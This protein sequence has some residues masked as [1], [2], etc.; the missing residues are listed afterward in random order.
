MQ[1]CCQWWS[2]MQAI[3]WS[4][5]IL[6]EWPKALERVRQCHEKRVRQKPVFMKGMARKPISWYRASQYMLRAHYMRGYKTDAWKV[7]IERCLNQSRYATAAKPSTREVVATRCPQCRERTRTPKWITRC[8]QQHVS[9]TK[10]S[11]ESD[12]VRK[13]GGI[14]RG[15]RVRT[16]SQPQVRTT[17]V[18]PDDWEDSIEHARRAYESRAQYRRMPEWSKWAVNCASNHTKRV[19]WKGDKQKPACPIE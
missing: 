4:P 2:A 6:C 10:R 9:K 18:A 1:E 3:K 8:M 13:L 7:G 5:A 15:Q 19:K 12:W 11:A 14:S 16:I 17:S